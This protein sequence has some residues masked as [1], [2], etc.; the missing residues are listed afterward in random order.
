MVMAAVARSL[1]PPC[2][3]GLP[4]DLFHSRQEMP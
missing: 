1:H 4:A 3:V 2:P